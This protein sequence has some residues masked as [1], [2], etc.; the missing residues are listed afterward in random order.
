MSPTS[1]QEVP[2]MDFLV[3]LSMNLN[4]MYSRK[5]FLVQ[6]RGKGKTVVVEQLAATAT[7]TC[8]A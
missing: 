8:V 5:K 7:L 4:L 3:H 2:F 1:V 6:D